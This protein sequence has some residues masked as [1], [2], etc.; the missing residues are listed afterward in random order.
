MILPVCPFYF[1]QK[2]LDDYLK[3][4]SV[5]SIAT[6]DEHISTYLNWQIKEIKNENEGKNSEELQ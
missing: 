3:K 6:S 1:Q 4:C 2:S 5:L